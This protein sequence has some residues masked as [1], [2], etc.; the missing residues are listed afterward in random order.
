[1]RYPGLEG[2]SQHE[3]QKKYMKGKGGPLVVM[4][5][6][7]GRAAG[8]KLINS[9]KLFSHVANVG[10]A[11]SLAIHP[12][13]TTHSQMSDEEQLATGLKPELVRLSVGIEHIED[14]LHD[15]NQGLAQVAAA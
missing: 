14:I 4:G 6:K 1:V 5:L 9:L 3:K 13:S 2:D 11:K 10:D 12:A 7:G 8:E 15:L